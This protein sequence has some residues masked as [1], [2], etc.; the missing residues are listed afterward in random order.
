MEKHFLRILHTERMAVHTVIA[1]HLI[2]DDRVLRIIFQV[3]LIDTHT[4]P[5]LIAR[6]D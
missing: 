1:A 4:V 5:Q 6:F 2:F 3:T